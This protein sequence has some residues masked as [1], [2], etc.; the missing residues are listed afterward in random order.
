MIIFL[1]FR[2]LVA[3]VQDLQAD[4]YQYYP[5][6]LN[7]LI[8]LLNTKDTEQLEWTFTC[9]AYIFKLLWRI[10]IKDIDNVFNL[11]LPLLSDTKPE[12]INNFAAES[13]AFVARKVKDKRNFL[14][15][16]LRTVRDTNDVSYI[17]FYLQNMILY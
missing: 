13:F 9:I 12:Y 16:L 14:V 5:N 4:F 11:L 1:N 2:I 7:V 17:L 8:E 15:I 10:L 6:F 3:L